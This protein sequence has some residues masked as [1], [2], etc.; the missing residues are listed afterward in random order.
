MAEISVSTYRDWEAGRAVPW[1]GEN[2]RRVSALFRVSAFYLLH[3][4][5]D[6]DEPID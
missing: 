2:L 6:D 1:P 3:G 4:G 5:E